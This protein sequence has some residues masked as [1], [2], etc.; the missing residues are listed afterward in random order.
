MGSEMCIRDS[1]GTDLWIYRYIAYSILS[2]C[3]CIALLYFR[4]EKKLAGIF[5]RYEVIKSSL[6]KNF[7]EVFFAAFLYVAFDCRNLWTCYGNSY[8]WCIFL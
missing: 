1:S 5:K 3:L 8:C 2:V 7:G 4:K 6:E